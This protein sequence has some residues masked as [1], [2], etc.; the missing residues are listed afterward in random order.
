MFIWFNGIWV[1][2]NKFSIFQRYRKNFILI[3]IEKTILDR[4]TLYLI[5]HDNEDIS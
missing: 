2:E 3:P 5:S 4:S 1:S